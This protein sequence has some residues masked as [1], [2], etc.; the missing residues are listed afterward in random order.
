MASGSGTGILRDSI[1]VCGRVRTG[2]SARFQAFKGESRPRRG[3]DGAAGRRVGGGVMKRHGPKRAK[4]LTTRLGK[5]TVERSCCRCTG[6]GK[7]LCPPG[8]RLGIGGWADGHGG[9]G[10]DG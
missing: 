1:S 6:C 5:V 4:T 2:D 7:G 10:G 3:R 8:T 9:R